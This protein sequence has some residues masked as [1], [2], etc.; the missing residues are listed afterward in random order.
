MS[1]DGDGC[2]ESTYETGVWLERCVYWGKVSE[3]RVKV[4][5]AMLTSEM[6][7]DVIALCACCAAVFPFAGET[8]VVGALATDVVVAQMVVEDLWV[9][10]GARAALP[11]TSVGRLGAGCRDGGGGERWCCCGRGGIGGDGVGGRR[12]VRG[13]LAGRRG[14]RAD[15][16]YVGDVTVKLNVVGVAAMLVSPRGRICYRPLNKVILIMDT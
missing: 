2:S 3:L 8:E 14:H 7:G 12:G 13:R 5:D 16:A 1:G 4:K 15:A 6:T 11:E 9:C 10:K